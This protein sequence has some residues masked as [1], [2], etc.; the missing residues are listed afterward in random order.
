MKL[1]STDQQESLYARILDF[2]ENR[3][4]ELQHAAMAQQL[5]RAGARTNPKTGAVRFPR[6]LVNEA[7]AQLPAQ[8]HLAPLDNTL[9]LVTL[10]HKAGCFSVC[11]GTGARNIIDPRTGVKRL[12][13][14]ADIHLWGRVA[15]SLEHIDLCA[16]PTPTDAPPQT[17]D[18]HALRALLS[19]TGKHVWI[20]PHTGDTLPYLLELVQA[21]AETPLAERPIASIIGCAL[22][23]LC[24][25]PMDMEVM[26][27][28]CRLGMPIHLSSLP[29]MGGTA[30]ITVAGSVALAAVEV[31]AMAV[32][33]QL[34]TPGH[35]VIGLATALGMDMGTGKTRKAS[36]EA[37]LA[38]AAAAQVIAHALHIPTHTAGMSTDARVRDDQA[39]TEHSLFAGL[40]ATAGVDIVGRAGEIEA[41]KTVCPLQL[42]LD[43]DIAATAKRLAAGIQW[44]SE[45]LAWDEIWQVQPGKHFVECEHTLRHCRDPLRLPLLAPG[46]E[47]PAAES[48]LDRAREHFLQVIET[49]PEPSLP[50]ETERAME[51]I[52]QAADQRLAGC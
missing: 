17:V 21:R 34:L 2:L 40:V 50:V 52:V 3:G 22:T 48:A 37:M 20:Q 36:V 14:E 6:Q 46:T 35:P 39:V 16:F 8:V 51:R 15:G 25:K 13:T 43:N 9:P 23:P 10:P 30:P 45:Q 27:Q 4:V 19:S 41:A 33:V 31:T 18:V 38:N 28:A 12:L 7:L 11:T 24:F 49:V 5:R 29:V 47:R 42:M 44:D 26:H 32:M 1:L